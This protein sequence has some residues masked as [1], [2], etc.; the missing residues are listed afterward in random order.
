MSDKRRQ[1]ATLK[2]K[3]ITAQKKRRRRTDPGVKVST[4]MPST[5]TRSGITSPMSPVLSPTNSHNSNKV[6]VSISIFFFKK[7]KLFRKFKVYSS[8]RKV[9][10]NLI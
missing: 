7:K 1:V 8:I 3:Q 2:A 4:N 5:P 10:L 9:N 6:Y